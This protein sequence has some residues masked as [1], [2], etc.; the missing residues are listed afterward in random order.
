MEK[1]VG[2]NLKPFPGIIAAADVLGVGRT[3][4][5][6]EVAAGRVPCFMIGNQAHI[7]V[8][9]YRSL[10]SERAMEAVKRG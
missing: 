2:K 10:L 3:W 4:L 9:A 7:D 8:E 1:T 6:K 5:R